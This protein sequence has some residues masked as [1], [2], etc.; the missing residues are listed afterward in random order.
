M[1]FVSKR[2]RRGKQAFVGGFQECLK[3][4]SKASKSEFWVTKRGRFVCEQRGQG[5]LFFFFC[6]LLVKGAGNKY[7]KERVGLFSLGKIER[8]GE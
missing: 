7:K 4:K 2:E 8:K 5:R 6:L 3:E 1:E